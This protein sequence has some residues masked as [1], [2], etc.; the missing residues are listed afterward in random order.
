MVIFWNHAALMRS[1]IAAY[2][3]ASAALSVDLPGSTTEI[4]GRPDQ[5]W[6]A[7]CEVTCRACSSSLSE[8]GTY[9]AR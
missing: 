5:V 7:G 3:C 1:S 8:D 2:S 4:S 9:S 6:P